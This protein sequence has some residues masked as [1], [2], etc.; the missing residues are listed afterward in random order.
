M[1]KHHDE[2][3]QDWI[4]EEGKHDEA[5]MNRLYSCVKNASSLDTA[6]DLSGSGAGRDARCLPMIIYRPQ[7]ETVVAPDVLPYVV[8]VEASHFE[9]KRQLIDHFTYKF[10]N[11]EIIWPRRH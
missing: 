11:N 4:M 9:L 1:L 3:D 6:Y 7:E 8:Q 5:D 10:R 2:Q